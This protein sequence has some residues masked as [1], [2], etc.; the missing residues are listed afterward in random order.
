MPLGGLVDDRGRLAAGHGV[1]D[2]RARLRRGVTRPAAEPPMA[3]VGGRVPR[4][5]GSLEPV[6]PC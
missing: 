4:S 6:A 2:E 3:P 5:N 1:V